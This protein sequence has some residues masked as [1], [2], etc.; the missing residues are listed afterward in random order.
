VEL[1]SGN[2]IKYGNNTVVGP[3]NQITSTPAGVEEVIEN[4]LNGFLVKVN[5]PVMTNLVM[6]KILTTTEPTEPRNFA[7]PELS[8]FAQLLIDARMLDAR[9]KNPITKENVPNLKVLGSAD[10][11]TA[12]F[13]TND[14]IAEARAQGLIPTDSDSL[15]SFLNYHFIRDDVIFSDGEKSGSFKTNLTYN[16]PV[17]NSIQYRNI[18]IINSPGNL[19]VE[20]AAGNLITVDQAD[21]NILVRKGVVHKINSILKYYE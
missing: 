1:S 11:W 8:E 14:A 17:D 15:L 19:S 2:F 7:D 16:D 5:H 21:A 13:P 10:Y 20:D 18:K 3:E 6:G 9:Y 12:F 4:E